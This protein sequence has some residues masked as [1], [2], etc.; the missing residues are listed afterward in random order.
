M[1]RVVGVKKGIH[2]GTGRNQCWY[3]ARGHKQQSRKGR[4]SQNGSKP[5]NPINIKHEELK[6]KGER[7]V[8]QRK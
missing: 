3:K 8:N 4:G 5:D 6:L 2:L 1:H 7:L